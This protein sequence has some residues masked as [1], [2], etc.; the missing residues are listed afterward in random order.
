MRGS[1]LSVP[2]IVRIQCADNEAVGTLT[3][4]VGSIPAG[5]SANFYM[6]SSCGVCGKA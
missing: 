1:I 6:T 3:L 5:S 2:E 4:G